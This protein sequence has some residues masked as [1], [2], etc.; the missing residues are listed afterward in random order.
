MSLTF[1]THSYRYSIWWKK[2]YSF[3]NVKPLSLKTVSHNCVFF[4]LLTGSTISVA[5]IAMTVVSFIGVLFLLYFV[6]EMRK[7]R[8]FNQENSP[9]SVPVHDWWDFSAFVCNMSGY[10][11]KE[12]R[13]PQDSKFMHWFSREWIIAPLH[14]PLTGAI[15]CFPKLKFVMC[16]SVIDYATRNSLNAWLSIDYV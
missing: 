10:S 1:I 8:Q 5:I 11:A 3:L 7:Q 14:V 13:A 16:N 4:L 9:L 12:S 6:Y 2:T 15:D